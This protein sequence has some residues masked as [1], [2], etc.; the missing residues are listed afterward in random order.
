M[1][2]FVREYYSAALAEAMR[3]VDDRLLPCQHLVHVEFVD[4]LLFEKKRTD[5][6]FDG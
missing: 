4:E 3:R 2:I 6:Q 5:S 1:K